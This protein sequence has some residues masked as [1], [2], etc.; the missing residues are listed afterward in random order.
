MSATNRGSIVVS[1]E[2]YP[3]PEPSILSIIKEINFNKVTSFTEPCRGEGHIYDLVNTPI[4]YHCELSE[5]TN[6]LTTTMPLVDLI[7][8]NPPFSLA[9]EFITKA[10][11]EA[12]TVIMLQRVNFLGSQARKSFWDKH[13]PTHL[14]ILSNRPKFIAT[15]TNTK[16]V[17]GKRVCNDKHSYQITEP[18]AI[19]V[20]CGSTTRPTSD[21]TEYAWFCWDTAELLHKPAGVHVL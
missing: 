14:F 19:C 7:L 6:Y 8:T 16:V 15:C 21:A 2:F 20:T 9:Q 17:D 3:T 10:L 12:R 13:P 11:T 4:K 1:Q 18:P 5:G